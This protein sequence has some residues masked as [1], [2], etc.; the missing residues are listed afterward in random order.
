MGNMSKVYFLAY[1]TNDR[2]F[3]NTWKK[4]SETGF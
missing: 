1:V 3:F 2:K 4:A